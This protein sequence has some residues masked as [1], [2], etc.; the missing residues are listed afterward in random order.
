LKKVLDISRG[1]S[2]CY[3]NNPIHI[4]IAGIELGKTMLENCPSFFYLR[5]RP[6]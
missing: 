1:E 5:H 4:D 6:E 3:F 2:G